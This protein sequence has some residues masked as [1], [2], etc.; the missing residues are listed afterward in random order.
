MLRHGV[1]SHGVRCDP[2]YKGGHTN[3]TTGAGGGA[4]T[5]VTSSSRSNGAAESAV[6]ADVLS[7]LAE[8]IWRDVTGR[9]RGYGY[10]PQGTEP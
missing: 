3:H 4:S 8:A 1:T 5:G 7:I 10:V 6:V 9:N 2:L